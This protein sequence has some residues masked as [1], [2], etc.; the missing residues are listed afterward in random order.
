MGQHGW[1][2]RN[3]SC[4]LELSLSGPAELVFCVAVAANVPLR[5]ESISIEVN[6][7]PEP[8]TELRDEHGTRLHQVHADA[9]TVVLEYAAVTRRQADPAPVPVLVRLQ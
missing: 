2:N 7:R 4:R 9:G 6:G 3:V 8:P 5:S 1:V